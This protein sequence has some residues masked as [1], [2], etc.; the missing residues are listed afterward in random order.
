MTIV[1]FFFGVQT[2]SVSVVQQATAMAASA[3]SISAAATQLAAALVRRA[4]TAVL[5]DARCRVQSHVCVCAERRHAAAVGVA[6]AIRRAASLRGVCVC[7]PVVATDR[8][9]GAARVGP[10]PALCVFSC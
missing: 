7:A 8:G 5:C 1:G 6:L 3:P 2:V 9:R 10:A 4:R